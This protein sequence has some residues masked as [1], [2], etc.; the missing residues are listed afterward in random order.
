MTLKI[1]NISIIIKNRL[2]ILRELVQATFLKLI[3]NKIISLV[4][5]T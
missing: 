5:T 3:I 1:V 4:T 2:T